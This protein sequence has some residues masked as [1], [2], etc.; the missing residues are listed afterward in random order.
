MMHTHLIR[1]TRW[2]RHARL[3]IA[4]L[5]GASIVERVR[6]VHSAAC[7][8]RQLSKW[9]IRCL[10]TSVIVFE[11]PQFPA[12]WQIYYLDCLSLRVF[13]FFSKHV[14][15]APAV[16][17]QSICTTGVCKRLKEADSQTATASIRHE[18]PPF[19]VDWYW[20]KFLAPSLITLQPKVVHVTTKAWWNSI[21]R[22]L[23]ALTATSSD[24]RYPLRME[25]LGGKQTI[26]R[27]PAISKKKNSR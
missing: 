11:G 24:Q 9:T 23:A 1:I 15:D 25:H 14:L 21:A 16:R 22:R 2:S 27:V 4:E 17:T 19:V 20:S 5:P 13:L 26:G 6:L 3:E 18:C 8:S 10:S 12:T 7:R